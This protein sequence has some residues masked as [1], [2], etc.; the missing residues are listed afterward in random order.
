MP[1]NITFRLWA[2]FVAPEAELCIIASIASLG[3]WQLGKARPMSKCDGGLWVFDVL[4]EGLPDRFEYKYVERRLAEEGQYVYSW[5]R[6]RN[7]CYHAHASLSAL[8]PID[9]Y[10]GSDFGERARYAGT[11]I[12]LFSLRSESDWGVGDF[13]VLKQMVAW[14]ADTK[15]SLLQLLPINDT[16]YRF[17]YSDSYPYNAIS[18]Y[19]I[20]PI[21]IDIDALPGLSDRAMDVQFRREAERLRAASEV[22][23]P[24]VVTLK[25]N[26]L[27]ALYRERGQE[28][29][30][31]SAAK[32]FLQEAESWLTP[33]VAY[34]ILRDRYPG[35]KP[36][37]WGEYATY[38]D[39]K[40]VALLKDPAQSEAIGFYA[41]IQYVADSQFA[42][43]AC[44][45]ANR[46]VLLKGDMPVGTNP[47]G[48]TAWSEAYY[49]DQ[50]L[51]IGAPPDAFSPNG[52]NWGFPLANKSNSEAMAQSLQWMSRYFS[53][54]RI[55]HVLGFFR[56]WT[57]PRDGTPGI[58]GHFY[59]ARGFSR[60]EIGSFGFLFDPNKDIATTKS[61]RR[62]F[63]PDHKTPDRYH[64][65]FL[66]NETDAFKTLP[67]EQQ[68]AWYAL[69]EDYYHAR[70]NDLWYDG[71]RQR[72]TQLLEGTDLLVCVED[73]GLI[74]TMVPQIIHE[75]DLLS[76]E[77]ERMPK[78]MGERMV[79]LSTLPY[80][81]VVTT[82]THDMPPLRL[83]WL[84]MQDEERRQYARDLMYPIEASDP[85]LEPRLAEAI[86]R[87]LLASLSQLAILPLVDWLA[88]S[89]LAPK[90]A[91][92]KEQTNDPT[93]PNHHWVYRMPCTVSELGERYRACSDLIACLIT[94]S[95]RGK[96]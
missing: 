82:S 85:I 96:L 78:K 6:G 52:Q 37:D 74:P 47:N 11:A 42:E 76:L 36:M 61:P 5:G 22:Q 80:R 40:V 55:D 57:I 75:I 49:Y 70:N 44:Y 33:Y 31:S 3:A 39:R 67:D 15:Q 8:R 86:V 16:S 35:A 77:L 50:S 60:E 43:V 30:A 63:V 45:A 4:L 64:P 12:P 32:M 29:L 25:L 18:N 69:N 56:V 17:D 53:V 87:R 19:A 72:L 2:P 89:H 83:W 1:T 62:A 46:G 95:G 10:Q 23:Y 58:L 84:E 79:D 91:A 13:G 28:M 66:F 26:Y 81:S 94:E 92:E 65:R 34:S 27:K 54:V 90:V 24:E 21:Y 71:G 20:H 41:W 93:N 7:L 59:P 48:A 38:D 73:L 51:S 9:L 68:A 88:T 14:A